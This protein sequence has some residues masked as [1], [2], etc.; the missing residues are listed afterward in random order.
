MFYYSKTK[1]N[2]VVQRC[3][4]DYLKKYSG[5]VDEA[6]GIQHPKDLVSTPSYVNNFKNMRS[7]SA[8]IIGVVSL[9]WQIVAMELLCPSLLPLA[10]SSQQTSLTGEQ[11]A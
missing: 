5:L 7:T 11:I 9:K 2:K 1:S 6:P 8:C 10:S 4:R 3:C